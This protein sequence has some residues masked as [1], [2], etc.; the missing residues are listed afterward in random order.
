[1]SAGK[2][3]RQ[4]PRTLTY[5]TGEDE[6]PNPKRVKA[7]ELD[8]CNLL[9]ESISP[10][11]DPDRVLLRRVIFL[12]EDKTKYVS[13][14]FY[15]ARD[16]QPFVELGGAQ[17]AP[18]IL[19]ESFVR[20]MAEQLPY[21]CEALCNNTSYNCKDGVFRMNTTGS[22]RIARVY[23]DKQY[24]TMKLHELRYLM[25]IMFMVRNQLTFYIAALND[26]KA[27]VNAAL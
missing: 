3:Q 22:Y 19:Q 10:A 6:D 7:P 14:G 13:I 9:T 5:L 15:P 2:R 18:L 26:V 4:P 27:Y 1:M 8:T 20:T 16:Y 12:R 21:L 24:T 23:L 17:K 11:F 25:Y